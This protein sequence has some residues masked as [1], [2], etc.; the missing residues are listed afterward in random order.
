MKK[1]IT[2]ILLSICI[3]ALITIMV[4]VISGVRMPENAEFKRD[5]SASARDISQIDV[6]LASEDL[7]VGYTEGSTIEVMQIASGPFQESWLADMRVNGS[8]LEIS[9][10]GG[11]RSPSGWFS[12]FGSHGYSR[13]TLLIPKDWEQNLNA[14]TSSGDIAARDLTLADTYL[15]STS[16]T[17][18]VNDLESA[19]FS[20]QSSSGDIILQNLSSTQLS[21]RSTSGEVKVEADVDGDVILEATSGDIVY[22]GN[23]GSLSAA[24][25]SGTISIDAPVEGAAD[26]SATSGDIAFTGSASTLTCSTSS[27]QITADTQSVAAF[28]GTTTSGDV[29]LMVMEA[30]ALTKVECD[31]SSGNVDIALPEGTS[32]NATLDSTSGTLNTSH[33]NGLIL[34]SDGIPVEVCTTS[35]DMQIR[36]ASL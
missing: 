4:V 12:L 9:S 10:P 23:A 7:E 14:T 32:I 1:P 35:G 36:S 6:S 16:G 8:T 26:L 18:G 3:V 29:R 2:I 24:T 17:I 33:A 27:G 21:A 30:S 5:F 28:S 15:H 25:S 11:A 20:L 31:T 22:A 19:D 34:V 13:I